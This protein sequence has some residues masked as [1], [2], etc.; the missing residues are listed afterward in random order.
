M[1]LAVIE[2]I[3]GKIVDWPLDQVQGYAVRD[4]K[5]SRALACGKDLTECRYGLV[6]RS[7]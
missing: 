2:W 7:Q 6:W 3:S 4:I 5:Q 1:K